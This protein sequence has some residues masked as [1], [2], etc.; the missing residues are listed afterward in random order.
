MSSSSWKSID[1]KYVNWPGCRPSF[2]STSGHPPS[3]E[4]QFLKSERS[5]GITGSVNWH[6]RELHDS[7]LIPSAEME[8]AH[9]SYCPEC[10]PHLLLSH[11]FCTWK[12][13]SS[14]SVQP[15]S[16]DKW[17]AGQTD[18]DWNVDD[19]GNGRPTLLS[20]CLFCSC[21]DDEDDDDGGAGVWWSWKMI[22]S[23]EMKT[24]WGGSKRFRWSCRN[25]R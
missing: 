7:K 3:R 4:D 14:P 5:A 12:H 22:R 11:R 2:R 9:S 8:A 25:L 19:D 10:L 18:S 20:S 13:P 1:R 23:L 21:V 15:D 16:C 6:L 17:F 24:E